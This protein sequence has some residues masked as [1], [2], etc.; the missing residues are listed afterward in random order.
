M[1]AA[2]HGQRRLTLFVDATLFQ[3]AEMVEAGWSVPD[4]VLGPTICNHCLY[5]AV[6]VRE[7][8]PKS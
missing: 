7:R 1:R 5:R 6:T 3:L 2:L 8:L 4:P